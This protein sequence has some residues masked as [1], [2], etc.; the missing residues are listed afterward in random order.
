MSNGVTDALTGQV[1]RQQYASATNLAK[2]Q[3]IFE[4]R[5]PARCRGVHASQRVK[6][7]GTEDVLDAGCGNG[8]WMQTLL[9]GRVR[10]VVGLDLSEG[11]LGD[12][13]AGLGG[14]VPLVVGDVQ[15]LPFADC[16]FDVVLAFWMLY[17]VP[18]LPAALLDFRR[19]LRPQGRLVASTNSTVRRATDDVL[20]EALEQTVGRR[21]DD[22]PPTWGFSA[23][24]GEEVLAQVFGRVERQD[25]VAAFSIPTPEP[26]LGYFESLRG[27]LE[28][29]LGQPLDWA[30]VEDHARHQLEEVISS[31]GVF[32]TEIATASFVCSAD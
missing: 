21:V 12:A 29:T 14:S 3:A 16:S 19:L 28:A 18:D 30:V 32:H 27:P 13:R 1:L 9:V 17:H 23:E 2:R 31:E 24:N 26:I 11:M 20:V 6:L 15:H 7:T 8:M 5:D 4:F 25:Y 22:W 10:S